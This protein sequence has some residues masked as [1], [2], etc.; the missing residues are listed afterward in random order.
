MCGKLN[1]PVVL[2]TGGA[3]RIGAAIVQYF[4]QQGWRVVIHCRNSRL[5][6]ETLLAGI[7][8]ETAG[9]RILQLDLLTANLQANLLSTILH[10][11]GRLDCLINNA[12]VYQRA[13]MAD[14]N[15]EI[16]EKGYAINFSVPFQLMREFRTM[17]GKG[18]II[19]LLDQR[20]VS[21]DP[22]SGAY[23]LAKKSLRDVTEACAL[24]WA[25]QIRVNAVAPGIVL[26]PPELKPETS[27]KRILQ[28]VPMQERSSEAE[29][30]KACY[31]LANATTITG[32]ILY[33]D[34][35]L[36]LQN[37]NLGEKPQTP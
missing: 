20:V 25:P 27:M 26:P 37:S 21:V 14:L 22:S 12:S 29:V 5:A 9:H 30:A 36:H 31:F 24:E 13:R 15:P 16:L 19:N 34:G 32:Q 7:G 4:A 18:N 10:D 8:G 33:V 2:V 28:Y 1:S 3:C 23:G 17:F 35:G 6:A 11:Y